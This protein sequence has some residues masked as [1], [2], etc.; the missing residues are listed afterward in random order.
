M[1]RSFRFHRPRG[2]FCGTGYCGL[3][4]VQTPTGRALACQ[5]PAGTTELEAGRDFLRPLGR[6]A[7]RFPPWFYERGALRR[8]PALHAM[9]RLTAAGRLGAFGASSAPKEWRED[10]VEVAVVGANGNVEGIVIG[11]YEGKVLGVVR[12]DALVALTFDRLVLD[13]VSYDVPPPVEGNDLPGVLGLRAFEA[14]ASQ[15]GLRAGQR[16]AVWGPPERV[17]RADEI[18]RAH[19]VTVSWAGE[20]PPSRI[21]GRG[22]V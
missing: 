18:A 5:T 8:A 6:I 16:A 13:S 15:G 4:K 12:R 7:E 19:G 9:R 11:V 22:R 10:R 21:E 14:Y 20:R 3:C 17:A 2:A 1:T